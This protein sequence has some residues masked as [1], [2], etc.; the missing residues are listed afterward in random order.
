MAE[1]ELVNIK[2]KNSSFGPNTNG[3]TSEQYAI[4]GIAI[5]M[6]ANEKRSSKN[7]RRRE[8]LKLH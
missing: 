1:Y 5:A 8:D 4:N 7:T 3:C 6:Y 2:G